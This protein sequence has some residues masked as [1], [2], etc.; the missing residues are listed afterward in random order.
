MVSGEVDSV[1]H[2]LARLEAVEQ[3]TALK[4][5]YWRACDAKDVAGFRACFIRD[6]AFVGLG[7]I[8]D[9]EDAG[10]AAAAFD[11]KARSR[12]PDGSFAVQDMHHGMHPVISVADDLASATGSWSLRMR[13]VDLVGRFEAV[14]TGEYDDRYVLEDGE[15]RIARSAFTTLWTMRRPLPPDTEVGVFSIFDRAGQTPAPSN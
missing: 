5:R 3:I 4:Y 8:G 1:T 14:L 13:H 2:R 12:A 6:G 7:A 10:D 11:E 15:W 9:F